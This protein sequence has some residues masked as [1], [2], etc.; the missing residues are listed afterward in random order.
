MKSYAYKSSKCRINRCHFDLHC[1]LEKFTFVSLSVAV[2]ARRSDVHHQTRPDLI[3]GVSRWGSVPSPSPLIP[4]T[5]L[6]KLHSISGE[7]KRHFCES[8][9]CCSKQLVWLQA[10]QYLASLPL[11]AGEMMRHEKLWHWLGPGGAARVLVSERNGRAINSAGLLCR[12][13]VKCWQGWAARI[14]RL[15]NAIVIAL[16]DFNRWN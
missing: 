2:V 15:T 16:F 5:R 6:R 7:V 3:D 8:F 13:I 9:S 12:V 4:P 14:K 10:D 11:L 1:A